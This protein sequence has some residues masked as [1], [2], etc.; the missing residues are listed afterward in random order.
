[1]H[2]ARTLTILSNKKAPRHGKETWCISRKRG[3]PLRGAK[4]YPN[5]SKKICKAPGTYCDT[6][7][8]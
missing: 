3:N 7:A 8:L 6:S 2:I 1:M 5:P 4:I